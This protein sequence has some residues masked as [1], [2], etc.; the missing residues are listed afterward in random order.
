[1]IAGSQDRI[2]PAENSEV[3]CERI[4]G[5]RLELIDGAGHLFFWEQPQRSAQLLREHAYASRSP[6][7]S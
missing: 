4:P 3:L 2:V 1:M 6:T 7:R 5:A